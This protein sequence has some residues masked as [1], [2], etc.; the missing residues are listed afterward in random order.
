MGSRLIFLPLLE[1]AHEGRI[2]LAWWI[3]KLDHV[4][5]RCGMPKGVRNHLVRAKG[6]EPYEHVMSWC[7]EKL[8]GRQRFN[9]PY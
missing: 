2:R 5:I 1:G 8:V 4:H 3:L 7:R 6:P 9:R